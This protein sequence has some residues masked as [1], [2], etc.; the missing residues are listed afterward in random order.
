MQDPSDNLNLLEE[1]D[2]EPDM[3]SS[4]SGRTCRRRRG[5][6]SPLRDRGEVPRLARPEG[7]FAAR[8]SPPRDRAGELVQASTG[9]IGRSTTHFG[10]PTA[11]AA[12]QAEAGPDDSGRVISPAPEWDAEC[13]V[14]HDRVGSGS[15]AIRGYVP[16]RGWLRTYPWVRTGGTG[17]SK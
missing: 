8:R 10:G 5:K 17:H 12:D 16:I 2:V 4:D 9:R 13:D 15:K 1:E 6:T 3:G 14:G 7:C 11:G